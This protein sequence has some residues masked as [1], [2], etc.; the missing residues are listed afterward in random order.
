MQQK[1]PHI[2]AT[3]TQGFVTED[4]FTNLERKL[5]PMISRTEVSRATGWLISAKTL[6]TTTIFIY[7]HAEIYWLVLMLSIHESRLS[8]ICEAN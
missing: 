6:I 2:N 1:F 5:S 3:Y 4:F 8:H 7:V